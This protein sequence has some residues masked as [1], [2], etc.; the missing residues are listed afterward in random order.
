MTESGGDSSYQSLQLTFNRRMARGLSVLAAYTISNRSTILRLSCPPRRTRTFR[1]TA[2]TTIWNA[3]FRVTICQPGH[4]RIGL[5]DPRRHPL[6]ARLRTQ[7]DYHRAI[8]SAVHPHALHDNSNTVTAAA[9]SAWIVQRRASTR[10][11]NR[12]PQEWFDV[13]AFAI[14][15]EYTWGNAGRNILRGPGLVTTD[16]SLRRSF[17]L[18]EKVRLV[19]EV[20]SFNTLNRAISTCRR[21]SP[22]NPIRSGNPLGERPAPDSDRPPASLLTIHADAPV[23]HQL[24]AVRPPAAPR[25]AYRSSGGRS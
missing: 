9:V 18:A 24:E 3:P 8:R 4:H 10:L 21:P 6:D 7:R 11:A 20:Q 14:P 13:S 23:E 2:T 22:I 17:A 1:R 15:P 19:G 16:L 25:I 12:S 5:P